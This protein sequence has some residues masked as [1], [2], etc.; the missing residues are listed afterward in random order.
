V[1][2]L[3]KIGSSG[4]DVFLI[5]RHVV[6]NAGTVEAANGTGELA[7]GGTV[8]LQDSVGSR[9]VFVETGSQGTV[10]NKG[11]I[12]AAQVSLQAADG[13]V[14]ALAGRGTRIR[15][16]GTVTRDGHVW[17]VADAGTLRLDGSLE[18]RN[19]DGSGG[20]VDTNA[21]KIFFGHG[22]PG[23]VEAGQWNITTPSFALDQRA[24]KW[25]GASLHAGTSTNVLTNG[26]QGA[27]G[28]IDVTSSIHWTGP[29]SLTLNA[30]RSVT[31]EKDVTVRNIG[32]GSV[33]LH[34][35][36]GS[37]D[38][39]GSIT[40]LGRIDWSKSTGVVTALYDMNG[41]YTPGTLLANAAW[42][43]PLYSGLATQIT[44]YQL[45]NSF[46]DLGKVPNNL[47]GNYALGT[48]IDAKGASLVPIG[49]IHSPF[50]GQFD[51]RGHSIISPSISASV[52]GD[53]G[54]P[55]D[56]LQTQGLF[57]VI[58]SSGVV[59]NLAI[60]RSSHSSGGARFEVDA[61]LAGVNYGT[62]VRVDATVDLYNV[63]SF[64]GVSMAGLVGLNYGRIQRSSSN[65]S[66]TSEAYVAGLVVYNGPS[67]SIEQ[68]YATGSADAF[69]HTPGSGGLVANNDGTIKQSYS[70]A[71]VTFS[72]NYC[73]SGR[74]F[75]CDTGAGGLVA[76]N[77]G[78]IAQSF[79]TGIVT[80]NIVPGFG[81]P[82]A[83]IAVSNSKVIGS[84]V[85]WNT[86]T[87]GATVGVL[88]GPGLPAANGLTTAQMSVSSSFAGYD[89]SSNG[90]WAMPA[91]ATNPVLRW[92]ITP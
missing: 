22:A 31:I 53:N 14:Y 2:N 62:V 56:R 15:A 81:L 12:K 39:G 79:A 1:I 52:D 32:T 5:A 21:G 28:D 10:V 90:V 38:N 30:N 41:S 49:D 60:Q 6:V 75:D 71:H 51:G 34:A 40:N 19:G 33:T 68:S 17:L 64:G 26:E 46:G 72:P 80:N 63:F 70:T 23:I 54:V 47:S 24:A 85:Y 58:G 48:N 87:T 50:S 20:T 92:E 25:L 61:G 3:G 35:D 11:Q 57:G 55:A 84:D 45:V 44:G 82:P 76:G 8:L 9:Q 86:Q 65:A 67:G 13:N 83:G 91:G 43:P 88:S 16:T 37:N 77:N 29:A 74:G 73:G 18:A 59:R 69:A 66:L 89:F 4:G 7:A 42:Q 36:A 27:S 78:T